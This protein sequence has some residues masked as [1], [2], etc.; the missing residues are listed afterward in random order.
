MS[1]PPI[2]ARLAT[3]PL[4]TYP[5]TASPVV[6]IRYRLIG[7]TLYT[8]RKS[9]VAQ[10]NLVAVLVIGSFRKWVQAD[11]KHSNC[12]GAH[13]KMKPQSGGVRWQWD[14][15][16]PTVDRRGG[17]ELAVCQLPPAVLLAVN[18]QAATYRSPYRRPT[19]W[20]STLAANWLDGSNLFA[21][22]FLPIDI[23][24]IDTLLHPPNSPP[25][26]DILPLCVL[27]L[28][29]STNQK[30]W[31]LKQ[32]VHDTPLCCWPSLSPTKARER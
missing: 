6:Q 18:L 16:V 10:V 21:K 4:G 5:R 29:P 11:G 23:R 2:L 24:D 12:Q 31:L 15:V 9:M 20:G 19:I 28:H 3:S 17:A 8:A 13:G 25:A 1:R 7:P 32:Y 14:A 30:Q 22:L 27:F 26:Q